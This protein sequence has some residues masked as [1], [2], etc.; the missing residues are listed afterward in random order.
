MGCGSSI[1]EQKKL[2]KVIIIQSFVRRMFAKK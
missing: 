2:E 1:E